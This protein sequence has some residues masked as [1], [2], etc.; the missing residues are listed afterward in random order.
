MSTEQQQVTDEAA[1]LDEADRDAPRPAESSPAEGEAESKPAAGTDQGPPG[2]SA[3]P[4]PVTDPAEDPDPDKPGDDQASTGDP[5]AK[6]DQD[7]ETAEAAPKADADPWEAFAPAPERKP[8]RGR[9]IAGAVGRVLIHEWTLAI[10]G[11]LALAVIM[12]WPTLRYPTHTIPQDIWDPT[13]QAWQMAWS[14]HILLTHPAQ[15][16]QANAFFPE[17]YSFAFSDT[18]LGY[19]P[20]GM[21]GSGPVAAIVR[22]N[23]MYV[24]LHALAFFGAYALIRQLGS[25][26]MGAAVAAVA[27]AYAPWRLA[28][29]GHMH[30]LST[31]GIAL[32]LAMLARGHGWSLRHGYRP[33]RTHAGWTLAGWLVATWQ[34]SLGF[35][36]GLP[37]A[38][39]LAGLAVLAALS[40]FI[41]QR[42]I[43]A[44]KRPFG[45]RLALSDLFGGLVFAAVGALLALSY[46]T[47]V[48]QH[49]EARRS[50]AEVR[51]FSPPLK[52]F[53]VAP[54]QSWLWGDLHAQAREALPWQPEMTLLPGFALYGLAA[55]GLIFSIWTV[56]QRL[57]LL[58]AL[59]A[60]IILAMGTQFFG[61]KGG[62]LVLY[63]AL[64]GWDGLRT[65][66]RLVLWTSLLLGILAAG[67]VSAFVG[68]AVEL[69]AD[70]VPARPG[71]WLRLATLIPLALVLV[72][73]FNTTPHPIVPAQP[74]ALRTVS[75]PMIVLPS[76]QLI[77]ENIM[78]WSTT[79]FQKMINGGSG[80]TPVRQGQTRQASQTFP[81]ANSIAYLTGLG[82]KTVVVLRDQVA[83]TPW[84]NAPNAPVDGLGITREEIG[85]AVVFHL[86]G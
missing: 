29:A 11:A 43:W 13:L 46:L 19:A 50:L 76:D 24:L 26:K 72:E 14:G 18:L 67:A 61:G 54:A 82:V 81:D 60:S 25:S 49:P 59:A 28:Q 33:E 37:F 39:I 30:V 6:P 36:I 2:G 66:G 75:G 85:N 47:V 21:I 84:Q 45:V 31:G 71:P 32:A 5:E 79:K 58:A 80:F 1:T 78:L 44:V 38:Y 83:G 9:R 86:G 17:R 64:P 34:I 77:D 23:I 63:R 57:L 51:Q 8:G 22:Y 27:F 3:T 35:G 41:H 42:F 69:T 52:G 10:L 73:G 15:L 70:R 4:T 56:R 12:T 20:A 55:A 7:G 68:R 16:W 74:A 48:D 65:P 40:W 62:Y 53:F